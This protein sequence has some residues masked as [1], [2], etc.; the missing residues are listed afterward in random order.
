MIPLQGNV[1]AEVGSVVVTA[2]KNRGTGEHWLD[3]AKE[4]HSSA[5]V[6]DVKDLMRVLV[7]LLPTPIFWALYDQQSSKWVFQATDLDGYV[8]WFNFTIQPDQMQAL[9]P[10]LIAVMIPLF[11]LVIYPFFESRR[12][13]LRPIARMVAGMVLCAA[14]FAISGVLQQAIDSRGPGEKQ[15]SLL[16]QIPQNVVMTA[17]EIMFSITGLEFAYSQAPDSMKAVVQAAW[18]FTVSAGKT[19]PLVIKHSFST[20]DWCPRFDDLGWRC[21]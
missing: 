6:E 14:A 10:I 18:L 16:W 4:N 2:V 7:L 12:Y 20:S 3:S 15:L 17:G 1:F 11:D 5:V 13:S 9:N 8:P 19:L 21:R